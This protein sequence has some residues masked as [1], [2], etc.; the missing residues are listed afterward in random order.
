MILPNESRRCLK[1]NTS[2]NVRDCITGFCTSASAN[3]VAKARDEIYQLRSRHNSIG[4][5]SN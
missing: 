2:Q 1:W 3:P 4:S 5:I